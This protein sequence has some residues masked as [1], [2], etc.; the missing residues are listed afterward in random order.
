MEIKQYLRV[1]RAH[2]V[3]IAVFTAVCILA[4]GAY[5]LTRE[6]V[7][8]ADTQL[9]VSAKSETSGVSPSEVY[10]GGLASQSRAD[11]YAR[12]VSSPPVVDAVI[13]ELDLSR[14]TASVQS[15]ITATVPSGTVLIDVTVEDESPQQAKEIADA[16]GEEF[17][18]FVDTLERAPET[19]ESPVEI[20]V[21]SPAVLPRS[22]ESL[23]TAVYLVAG[24][25]LGLIL[26]V[27]AAVVREVLDTRIRDDDAAEAVAGARVLG[28][29]PRDAGAAI[30]PL[31]VV[32]EPDSPEAEAYR[33]LRTN[34]RVVTIDQGHR[35]LLITSAASG[36]GKTL[37]AANLGFAFAQ[38]GHRVALVDADL[39]RPRLAGLLELEPAPGLSDLLSGEE[40]EEP[41]HYEHELPLEVLTAGTPPP[42]PSELLESDRFGALLDRLT[43][44]AELVI[45][46]SP[47]L[48]PVSDAAV[49][50]R[51][52]AAVLMVARV[53]S[54]RAEALDAAAESL[55]AV[56]KQPVGAVL[57]A[58]PARTGREYVYGPG[59]GA[60]AERTAPAWHS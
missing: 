56:G 16:L 24:G 3:L 58:V 32:D 57:N 27:A 59:A 40:T 10:Q 25:L 50:A 51:M 39:R 18:R 34:L 20:T 21:T 9:F 14:S 22:P 15:A 49:I 47:A 46:D 54:T 38:A 41:M 43:E 23:P 55:R 5:T 48:L 42:N 45:V 31:V 60:P 29:I 17:P 28:H 2:W 44:R 52:T 19:D 33:R 36:E 11:S 12:I 26:G 13:E 8:A 1:L 35:S 6:S 30:R 7:Y 37:V 53:P 4:A